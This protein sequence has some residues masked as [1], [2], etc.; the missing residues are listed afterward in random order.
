[1]V[2]YLT[3]DLDQNFPIIVITGYSGIR[4]GIGAIKAGAFEYLGSPPREFLSIIG[5]RGRF[6]SESAAGMRWNMHIRTA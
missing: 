2:K 1:M 5:T 3:K 4:G 6:G